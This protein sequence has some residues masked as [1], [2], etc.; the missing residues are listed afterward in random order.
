MKPFIV[1]HQTHRGLIY[2]QATMHSAILSIFCAI[3]S[4][5]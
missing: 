2:T 4:F 5:K 3:D 1:E